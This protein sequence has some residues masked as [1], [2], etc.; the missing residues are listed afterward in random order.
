MPA[1][2]RLGALRAIWRAPVTIALAAA[3]RMPAGIAVLYLLAQTG[4]ALLAR[5]VAAHVAP[6]AHDYASGTPAGEFVGFAFLMLAVLAVSDRYVPS[7][8]SDV[9]IGAALLAGLLVSKGILNPAIAL[10]EGQE[11]SAALWAPVLSGLVFTGLFLLV[12]PSTAQVAAVSE[13]AQA[14][15]DQ[16]DEE[17]DADQEDP[18]RPTPRLSA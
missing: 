9:A 10:A 2:A 15:Q 1:G 12:A 5:L 11:R 7:A 18:A 13:Q 6:L 4:G 8:G 16:P 17:E 3:R 14:E